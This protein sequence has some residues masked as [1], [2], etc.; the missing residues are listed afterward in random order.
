[1][2]LDELLRGRIIHRVNPDQLLAGRAL[3]RANRDIA[4]AV[5]L[6]G[7]GEFD[8]SL[9]IA[10]NAMLSA[11]RAMMF[12]RGYRPSSTEGHVA[13][14]RF[15]Q[16]VLGAEVSDRMVMVMNGLRK[17]RHVIVYEE[18]GVVS[19]DEAR[20]AVRWAEEF[21]KTMEPLVKTD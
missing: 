9:A 10:Y 6:I 13:V 16:A 7:S 3:L 21:V 2:S 17:K 1:V 20:Q 18:M 8:W 14:V 5:T 12:S 11:G 4:T 19:G 15:L